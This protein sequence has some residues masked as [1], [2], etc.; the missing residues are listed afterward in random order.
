MNNKSYQ[1]FIGIDVAKSKLDLFDSS[2]G[3]TWTVKNSVDEIQPLIE[4]WSSSG[5][6]LLVVME[7]TGG[8]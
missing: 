3:Q 7:A 4:S 5:G 2:T 6:K 1:T 8:Y